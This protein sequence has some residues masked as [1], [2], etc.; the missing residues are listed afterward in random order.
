[1]IVICMVIWVYKIKECL[2]SPRFYE[3]SRMSMPPLMSCITD[4]VLLINLK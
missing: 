4:V 3:R 1:M 2:L